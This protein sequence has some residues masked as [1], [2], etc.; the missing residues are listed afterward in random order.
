MSINILIATALIECA[1]I[2]A[3]FVTDRR[4]PW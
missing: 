3:Q 2:F 1:L 4:F